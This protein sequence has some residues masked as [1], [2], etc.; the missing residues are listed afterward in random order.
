MFVSSPHLRSRRMA[1][2][3]KGASFSTFCDFLDP[4]VASPFLDHFVGTT[5]PGNSLTMSPLV[6]LVPLCLLAGCILLMLALCFHWASSPSFSFHASICWDCPTRDPLA[7]PRNGGSGTLLPPGR[8]YIVRLCRH[9]QKLAVFCAVLL[10]RL[11]R[12]V[13][14][15]SVLL[16]RF[17]RHRLCR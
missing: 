16:R 12:Y 17:W 13:G 4:L 14:C 9:R 1:L 2:R 11:L 15:H 3:V 8:A 6:A 5:R 10:H 7:G